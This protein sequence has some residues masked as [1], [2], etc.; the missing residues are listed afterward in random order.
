MSLALIILTVLLV[1][2]TGIVLDSL[3]AYH[4]RVKNEVVN[5][6]IQVCIKM[7][8]DPGLLMVLTTRSKDY[9]DE[10]ALNQINHWLQA[11]ENRYL[12]TI[13]SHAKERA[14]W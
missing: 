10:Q 9:S 14:M 6:M 11:N 3:I 12:H 7:V 5:A 13:M 4:F 2:L 1:I 8:D